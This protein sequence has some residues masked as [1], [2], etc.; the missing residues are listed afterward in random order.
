MYLETVF[1][2]ETHLSVLLIIVNPHVHEK[3]I[4]VIL[5][6]RRTMSSFFST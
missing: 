3:D 4:S 6:L 5:K 2:M 1:E